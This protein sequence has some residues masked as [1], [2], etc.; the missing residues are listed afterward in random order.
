[1]G[2]GVPGARRHCSALLRLNVDSLCQALGGVFGDLLAQDCYQL[3]PQ[4][5]PFAQHS[6]IVAQS[7]PLQHQVQQLVP[8]EKGGASGGAACSTIKRGGART[9]SRARSRKKKDASGSAGTSQATPWAQR[10]CEGAG[11]SAH[12]VHGQTGGRSS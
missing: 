10:P 12:L 7:Q 5:N 8:T 2:T 9:D 3:Q 1:M 6:N 11:R 4:G